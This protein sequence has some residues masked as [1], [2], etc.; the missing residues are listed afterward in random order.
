MAENQRKK[1]IIKK[2]SALN[3]NI[4][5]FSKNCAMALKNMAPNLKKLYSEEMSSIKKDL[6]V[7]ISVYDSALSMAYAALKMPEKTVQEF[8]GPIF[9]TVLNFFLSRIITPF[10]ILVKLMDLRTYKAVIIT[11]IGLIKNCF[12]KVFSTLWNGLIDMTSKIFGVLKAFFNGQKYIAQLSE[13]QMLTEAKRQSFLRRMTDWV[14]ER[15]AKV[16]QYCKSTL[17]WIIKRGFQGFSY[18]FLKFVYPIAQCVSEN[19]KINFEFSAL[20]APGNAG[21]NDLAQS[22]GKYL[23]IFGG[24]AVGAAATSTVT[25]LLLPLSGLFVAFTSITYAFTLFGYVNQAGGMIE[26]ASMVTDVL[27]DVDLI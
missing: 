25:T 16:A 22:I 26:M 19:N 21:I 24:A 5:G 4:E 3:D 7:K 9:G 20:A 23:G 6:G 10:Q 17:G 12:P 13:R 15:A 11:I 18:M 14:K 2:R 1:I 8:C 27:D